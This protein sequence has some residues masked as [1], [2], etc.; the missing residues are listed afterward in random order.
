[1]TRLEL[2]KLMRPIIMQAT[3]VPMCILA[4][5]NEE[6]P[7]GE[8]C[9]VEPEAS[10][11]ER[12]HSHTHRVG[13]ETKGTVE[14]VIKTQIMT[15]VEINF[16]RGDARTRAKRLM[17]AN[18]RPSISAMLHKGSIGWNRTGPIN[19]LTA[20]QSNQREQRAQVSIYIMYVE[21]DEPERHNSIEQVAWEV[22]DPTA[23]ILTTGDERIP[24]PSTIPLNALLFNGQPLTYNG[25]YI[26]FKG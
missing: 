18:K 21:S 25:Q 15:Q 10:V 17:N 6:A 4:D 24:E 2:F 7:T 20:L 8:Y 1:M 22:Q 14:T 16:Y 3:G 13:T 23:R 11:T 19:D 26:T 9:S 12:G 5:Q